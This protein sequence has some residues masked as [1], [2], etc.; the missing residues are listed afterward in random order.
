[1]AVALAQ[2][3][4]EVACCTKSLEAVQTAAAFRPHIF[5][6]DLS[7]PELDGL[8]LCRRIRADERHAGARILLITGWADSSP[9]PDTVQLARE[10]G[11]QGILLKP[12]SLD[13]LMSRLGDLLPHGRNRGE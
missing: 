13:A 9:G 4:Y 5:L 2:I 11:A 3:G 8:Q 7:M 1:M 6:V 10:A 12:F